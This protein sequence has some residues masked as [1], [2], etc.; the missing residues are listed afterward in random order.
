MVHRLKHLKNRCSVSLLISCVA[1]MN[2]LV[3]A[4]RYI[5]MLSFYWL[6]S[7]NVM[8]FKQTTLPCLS[9]IL[10]KNNSSVYP[11]SGLSNFVKILRSYYQKVNKIARCS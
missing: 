1:V 2:I 9:I 3:Q 6:I 8:F 7:L 5:F 10:A 11:V 4:L